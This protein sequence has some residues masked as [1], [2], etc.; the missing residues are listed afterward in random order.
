MSPP[1]RD[2]SGPSGALRH[3]ALSRPFRSSSLVAHHE[4]TVHVE[5]LP[6]H[7]V[8]VGPGEERH[9]AGH[10]LG[11]LGAS[12]RDVADPALPRLALPQALE[13]APLAVA[14]L[15]HPPLYPPPA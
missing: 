14:L 3:R 9:H 7:V 2:S 12:Q 10:I 13:G 15:P 11:P 8:G 1:D 5:G 6:G 4:A